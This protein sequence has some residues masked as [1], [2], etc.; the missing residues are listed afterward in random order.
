MAMCLYFDVIIIGGGATGLGCAVDSAARGLKTLLLEKY[1]FAKGTSS[2]S[3]KLIHG[4][5][6]YLEQGHLSLVFEALHERGYLLNNA[7]ELVKP[8]PFIIPAYK[9]WESAV[10]SIGLKLYDLLAGRFNIQASKHLSKKMVLE[11]LPNLQGKGLR[12][13]TLFY[14]AGFD[15]ARLAIAL[16]RTCQELGGTLKNY[17]PVTSLIKNDGKVEGVVTPNGCY[18]AQKIINATGVFTDDLRSMDEPLKSSI[19]KVSQG[20]HLVL[21]KSFLKSDHALLIPH[22]KDKRLLFM[23]P[24]LDHVLLGTTDTPVNEAEIEP[25]AKDSEINFILKNAAPYLSKAPTKQDILSVFAGLRP[26]VK[27]PGKLTKKLSRSHEIFTSKSGLMTIT[28]GKWTTYRKM[29]EDAINTAFPDTTSLT[30]TLKLQTHSN[31]KK[32]KRLHKDL[33][34]FEEDVIYAVRFEIAQTLDDVLSR[35]TRALFLNAKA[36]L[37]IAPKVADIMAEELKRDEKWIK[38][39]LQCFNTLAKGYMC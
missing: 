19:I 36:A 35:R 23:V 8:L 39:Q 14:D 28:G 29:G 21:P 10:F 37:E 1:D 13:G 17:T 6:R 25:H 2:R 18:R 31:S 7:P 15:D 12:G 4:G 27:K 5:L 38:T 3:T 30:K 16:M 11:R 33:P 32:G 34:Y 24:W 9:F 26:L 20:I 22:T